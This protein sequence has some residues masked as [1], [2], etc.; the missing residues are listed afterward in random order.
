MNNLLLDLR[1]GREISFKNRILLIIQLSLP[2]ILAQLSSVVMQYIDASMVGQLGANDSA[3]IGLVSSTTW[4]L[5][6]INSAFSVGFT[7]Q[8][9]QLIGAGQ[10][11]EARKVM[12]QGLFVVFSL[13]LLLLA[14]GFSASFWM[15]SWLGGSEDIIHNASMYLRVYALFIPFSTLRYMAGGSLQSSGNMKIP[16]MLNILMCFL[17]VIFNFILIFP[18]HQFLKIT[19]PGFNLRVTGAALG[20]ALSEVVC[21][22]CMLYFLLV[23]SDLLH[24]RKEEHFSWNKNH[25]KNAAQIGIPVAIESAISSSA[26]IAFTKI[27]APLGTISI[28]ANSFSITAE[29]LCYMPG[30]GIGVAATTIIG[31]SIGA[32]RN[33]LTKELGNLTVIFGM[34]IMACSGILMYIFA[35]FMIGLLT[36]NADIQSLAIQILRI[37]A[38]AEPLYGASII[39][40]GI[41]RG[42]GDTLVSTILNFVSMWCV[43]I[44][45]AYFLS[46]SYGL[47]GVW[48]AMSFELCFRGIIF[49]IRFSRNKWTKNFVEDL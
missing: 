25:L 44:P 35:P 22:L 43:R 6:G 27:V 41:F 21:A 31:Q 33:D 17:D 28:A 49:L 12:K 4:F 38:F 5:G 32:K 2:S 36:P 47:K 48:F 30:Y 46:S 23:K 15:P 37:E 40:A 18:S 29:S 45:L 13:S 42:A 10:F 20:T 3:S 1:E 14:F 11:K 7:V 19:I 39:C 34:L 9:A 16:S 8:I 26:Y 24:L